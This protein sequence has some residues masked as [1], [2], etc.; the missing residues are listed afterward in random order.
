MLCRVDWYLT[1]VSKEHSVFMFRVKHSKKNDP[2]DEG[3]TL[4]RNVGNYLPGDMAL[5]AQNN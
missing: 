2:D 4:L 1:D 5:T 3:T